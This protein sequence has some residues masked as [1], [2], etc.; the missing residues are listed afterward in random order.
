MMSCGVRGFLGVVQFVVVTSA[1]LQHGSVVVVAWG[2]VTRGVGMV[3]RG[4]GM[5]SRGVRV[6]AAAVRRQGVLASAVVRVCR[7]AKGVGAV[8]RGALLMG[9]RPSTARRRTA[10]VG[11]SE[12]AR[13]VAGVALRRPMGVRVGL[14]L[15][16]W[17]SGGTAQ[18]TVVRR[19]PGWAE[20]KETK[21]IHQSEL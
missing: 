21:S 9:V 12:A 1:A 16:G 14:I 8:H 11:G 4:M 18:S 20:Q 7:G 2:V 3:S 15:R 10:L 6:V 17:A 19:R 13:V 5:V